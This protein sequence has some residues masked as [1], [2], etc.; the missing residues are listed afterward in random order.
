[1]A[2][3]VNK[4]NPQNAKILGMKKEKDGKFWY[5]INEDGIESWAIRD[6]VFLHY[7]HKLCEF[8]EERV[9]FSD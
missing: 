4:V 7:S 1:M 6:Y 3:K 5:F 2:E 8:Y 9:I